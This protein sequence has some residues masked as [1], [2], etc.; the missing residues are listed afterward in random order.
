MTSPI[1]LLRDY[2]RK[3]T[4]E[5]PRALGGDVEGIHQ[6][7]VTGRRLRLALTVLARKPESK[8]VIR[9]R[10]ELRSLTRAAS[11]S[12]DLD[13]SY[14]T[15]DAHTRETPEPSAEMLTLLRRLKAARRRSRARTTENLLDTEMARLRRD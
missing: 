10:R 5:I 2:E 13:V 9:A 11:A 8:R 12:R 7:R 1:H 4:R 15:F 3:L 6:L 14:D